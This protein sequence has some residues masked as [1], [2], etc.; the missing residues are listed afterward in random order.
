MKLLS[1]LFVSSVTL[2]A[3]A[4]GVSPSPSVSKAHVAFVPETATSGL[5]TSSN[6]AAIS[7]PLFGRSEAAL[8]TR[9]GATKNPWAAYNDSLDNH[10]LTT[11]AFTSLVGWALGDALTQ[12][13]LTS[14]AFDWKRFV[15]LSA[16]GFLYHG[17]SGHFFYDWLDGKIPGKDAKSVAIKVAIDQICWCPLFMTVFFTYLGLVNGDSVSTIGSKIKNDLL[18]ACQGSWKLWPLVHTVNFAVVPSKYRLLFING[19]QVGFNM[20]LSL[21]GTK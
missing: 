15:T 7:S 3:Q 9:G 12:I 16:F 13:F 17:P 20:F 14:G 1:L 18:S 6:S 10:P 2:A 5:R 19:V 21:L 11:K 4:F 8:K